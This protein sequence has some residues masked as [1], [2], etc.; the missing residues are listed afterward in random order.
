M[1]FNFAQNQENV[2]GS[3]IPEE[4]KSFYA[5][6]DDGTFNFKGDDPVVSTAVSA[7]T[8]MNSALVKERA[9][10]ADLK[11]NRIDLSVLSEYGSD[12]QSIAEGIQTRMDAMKNDGGQEAAKKMENMKTA[13]AQEFNA[14][15]N[16][17][18][19][20]NEALQ[21]QLY[22]QLVT[23]KAVSAISEHKGNAKLLMPFVKQQVQVK[24]VDGTMVETVVDDNGA[25]RF[26]GTGLPMTVSELV[27]DMKASDDYA[28]CFAS[29]SR[30]GGGTPPENS[31]KRAPVATAGEERSSVDKIA[32]GLNA[33]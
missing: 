11:K 26:N 21:S 29:E 15:L 5:K 23:T 32:D 4:F 17:S 7:L 33:M 16:A 22:D 31:G 25:P 6:N 3:K 10:T 30:K 27:K 14:K 13:M 8:G 24:E 18:D 9:I 12:V 20:R 28:P 19:K 1:L 2:D